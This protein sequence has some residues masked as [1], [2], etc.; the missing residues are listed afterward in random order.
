MIADRLQEFEPVSWKRLLTG[1]NLPR[2]VLC[3][4]SA[5][6]RN[7]RQDSKVSLAIF[8]SFQHNLGKRRTCKLDLCSAHF[9]RAVALRS[10]RGK[11]LEGK[12]PASVCAAVSQN[13]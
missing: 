7:Q 3:N 4:T 9:V 11:L 5:S 12:S 8:C 1:C 2:N 13:H 10:A 6:R